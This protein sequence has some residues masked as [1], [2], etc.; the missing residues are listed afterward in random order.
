M[1]KYLLKF[2]FIIISLTAATGAHAQFMHEKDYK[3]VTTK[4]YTNIVGSA[5][6]YEEWMPGSV[7][8]INGVASKEKMLLKYDLLNDEVYFK[9]KAGETMAFVVPVQE[10][11]LNPTEIDA[12]AGRRFRNGYKDID[13]A[14][15]TS[16]YEV[17]SDGKVQLLK[18]FS[19]FIFESQDIGSATKTKTFM[20][21]TKYYLVANGKAMPVKNERKALLA[22]LSDKQPELDAWLKSNKVN[23]KSDAGLG[24][25]LDYYNAL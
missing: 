18:K 7:K 19:K 14:R 9:D 1:M 13:G 25:L 8:L 16:F 17:L 23:F 15:P 4:E 3:P 24:K 2:L 21:K 5:Y 11:I 20:D 12:A 6:L 10:F 22:A